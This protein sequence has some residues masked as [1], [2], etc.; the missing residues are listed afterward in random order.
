MREAITQARAIEARAE[1]RAAPLGADLSRFLTVEE[2]ADLRAVMMRGAV[3][4]SVSDLVAMAARGVTVQ[5]P[6]V[7]PFEPRNGCRCLMCLAET[8]AIENSR[9][10]F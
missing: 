3:N 7:E 5:A 2:H 8:P 6:P 9:N 10:F 1:H 4:C